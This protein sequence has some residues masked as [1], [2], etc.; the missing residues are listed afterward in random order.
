MELVKL[1][2]GVRDGG[3]VWLC[4]VE[5]LKLQEKLHSELILDQLMISAGGMASEDQRPSS[6]LLARDTR[7]G[8]MTSEGNFLLTAH[9]LHVPMIHTEHK[10]NT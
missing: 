5:T 9:L 3:G 6:T 10:T 1:F 8:P 7:G 4:D 2:D